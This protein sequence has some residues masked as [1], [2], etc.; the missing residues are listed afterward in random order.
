MR[1]RASADVQFA[2][3]NDTRFRLFSVHRMIKLEKGGRDKTSII[4]LQRCQR[5][6]LERGDSARFVG[7]Q[8]DIFR[9]PSAAL[10]D[11]VEQNRRLVAEN[12]EEC[13]VPFRDQ[14]AELGDFLLQSSSETAP[15]GVADSVFF[16]DSAQ[17]VETARE[18][19]SG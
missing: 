7:Y 9:D 3:N 18:L 15:D 13:G 8:R 6:I 17:L 16:R 19:L 5:R 2:G 12:H 4:I 1:S 10:A 11:G 14:R